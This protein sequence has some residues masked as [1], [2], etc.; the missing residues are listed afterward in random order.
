ACSVE[1]ELRAVLPELLDGG[2]VR[3]QDLRR[4]LPRFQALRNRAVPT[5]SSRALGADQANPFWP[6]RKRSS[7]TPNSYGCAAEGSRTAMRA[8]THSASLCFGFTA[9]AE[10][11]GVKRAGSIAKPVVE[12]DGSLPASSHG[13]PKSRKGWSVPRPSETFV[14]S[15]SPSPG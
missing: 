11:R 3:G 1:Q 13:A 10:G 12:T 7:W 5:R 6:V 2:P 15:R 9:K 14:A 4:A 8:P